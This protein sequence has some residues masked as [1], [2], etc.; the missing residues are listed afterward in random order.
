MIRKHGSEAVLGVLALLVTVVAAAAPAT[1][2]VSPAGNDEDA[3]GT[4]WDDSFKTIQ[5]AVDAAANGDTIIVSNGVYLI[6]S[7]IDVPSDKT[8]SIRSYS[9]NMDDVVVDGQ[10]LTNCFVFRKVGENL[11]YG[12]TVRNGVGGPFID[13]SAALFA[14]G[15]YMAGGTIA[16]CRVSGCHTR[17]QGSSAVTI[18][19]GGI[20]HQNGFISNCCVDGCAITNLN[21]ASSVSTVYGGGIYTSGQLSG[22]VVSNCEIYVE[23]SGYTGSS[24]LGCTGGGVMFESSATMTNCVVADCRA[25]SG[26]Q[27]MVGWGGG[28]TIFGNS[29]TILADTL[30]H[31]CRS[32]RAGGGVTLRGEGAIRGC[33]VSD[34][35]VIVAKRDSGGGNVGGGIQLDDY[36][37]GA[38]IVEN[39]LVCRNTIT[40]SVMVHGDPSGGGGIGIQASLAAKP[41]MVRNCLLLDNRGF[42]GGAFM[43]NGGKGMVVSNC[44]ASGNFSPRRGGFA[45]ATLAPGALFVDC[46]LDGHEAK[47]TDGSAQAGQVFVRHCEGNG[48]E[49]EITFRNC[50]ITGNNPNAQTA[51]LVWIYKGTKGGHSPVEFEQCTFTGNLGNNSTF[52]LESM[53]CVSNFSAKGCALYGNGSNK[54]LSRDVTSVPGVMT[55]T[56]SNERTNMPSDPDSHNL[57]TVEEPGFEDALNGNYRLQASSPLRDAGGAAAEW[58]GTGRKN[59]PKDMGDGTFTMSAMPGTTHGIVLSRNN[60]HPRL[61]NSVPDVGCFEFW[62]PSG[63]SANFR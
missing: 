32:S 24:V 33:T 55:Y 35:S 51:S 54:L 5:R 59:G 56:Y 45:Y 25:V 41:A 46:R 6:D 38:R 62:A 9:G 26:T 27:S 29:R 14:G 31:G 2:H 57:T 17:Y 1:L 7:P 15:V 8:L 20:Y 58:M 60:A 16:D 37:T 21:S 22:T 11:L 50:Y 47:W 48:T 43:L 53:L 13:G 42:N 36:A 18:R 12:I 4:G 23:Y 30:V 34:N 52:A 28:I 40:N 49:N 44:W 39:C 61:R 63:F 19:G 3:G 10:H